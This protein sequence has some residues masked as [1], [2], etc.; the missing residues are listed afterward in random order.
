MDVQTEIS[1]FW[2]GGF[3]SPALQ[4]AHTFLPHMS[5]KDHSLAKKSPRETECKIMYT[6]LKV[7]K[8]TLWTNRTTTGV[9]PRTLGH[10]K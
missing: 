4:Q 1:K 5:P 7:N 8:N 10:P 9:G 2:G 3:S 6:I